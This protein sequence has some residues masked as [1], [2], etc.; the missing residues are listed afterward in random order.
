MFLSSIQLLFCFGFLSFSLGF[1]SWGGYIRGVQL[2]EMGPPLSFL[3]FLSFILFLSF[4]SF[5]RRLFLLP[6]LVPVALPALAHVLGRFLG[7]VFSCLFLT[8]P[9]LK[10]GES[11]REYHLR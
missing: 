8:S 1:F 2:L 3:L 4:W 6:K 11:V 10:L 7:P 5:L 9:S